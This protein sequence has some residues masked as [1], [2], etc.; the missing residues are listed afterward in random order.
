MLTVGPSPFDRRISA[1]ALLTIPKPQ[2]DA[3]PQTRSKLYDRS[4]GTGMRKEKKPRKAEIVTG[5]QLHR[6][7]MYDWNVGLRRYWEDEFSDASF[8]A[9]RIFDSHPGS[10]WYRQTSTVI[11]LITTT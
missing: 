7:E 2:Q 10:R 1:N 9:M 3:V 4:K 5:G 8:M 6:Q 11:P